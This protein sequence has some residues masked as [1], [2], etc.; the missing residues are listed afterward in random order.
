VVLFEPGSARLS[1]AAVALLEAAAREAGE[2]RPTELRLVASTASGEP[3]AL[4]HERAAAVE[5]WLRAHAVA[6]VRIGPALEGR[7][8][9]LWLEP[10]CRDRR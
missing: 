2:V 7:G 4:A 5:E 10:T 3:P 6:V 8:A 9:A 1:T